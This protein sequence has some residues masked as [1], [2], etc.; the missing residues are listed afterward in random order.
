MEK[1]RTSSFKWSAWF[2]FL[3]KVW[4]IWWSSRSIRRDLLTSLVIEEESRISPLSKESFAYFSPWLVEK[5]PF[6]QDSLPNFFWKESLE[7]LNFEG[8]RWDHWST[9]FCTSR[10][11]G[12]PR[13][14]FRIGIKSKS[15]FANGRKKI[16]D[17]L[18]YGFPLFLFSQSGHM[19]ENKVRKRLEWMPHHQRGQ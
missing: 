4:R 19:C 16:L 13:E 10:W 8:G 1:G 2:C 5:E 12:A 17:E 3:W 15:V 14:T 7:W 6:L 9:S 11:S 18:C